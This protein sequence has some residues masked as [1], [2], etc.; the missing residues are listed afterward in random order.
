MVQQPAD[1]QD[2]EERRHEHHDARELVGEP[3]GQ[4]VTHVV[5]E[6]TLPGDAHHVARDRN[7]DRRQRDDDLLPQRAI[8]HKRD[9]RADGDER[10]Q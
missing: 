3:L 10:H 5:V 2:Q 8:G 7:R 6:Q 4:L 9:G 1:E